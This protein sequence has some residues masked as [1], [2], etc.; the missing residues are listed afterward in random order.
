[1]Q[2][3]WVTFQASYYAQPQY[4]R[5]ADC[6]VTLKGM[7]KSG[8]TTSG[9]IVTT[10]PVGY[11]PGQALLFG[12]TAADAYYR[13]QIDTTGAVRLYYPSATWTSLSNIHF[14]AGDG[15]CPAY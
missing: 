5:A 8:V 13:V 2:N 14:L 15:S 4:T 9:T 3:S 1:M 10:L 6:M 12:G 11:R 7:I